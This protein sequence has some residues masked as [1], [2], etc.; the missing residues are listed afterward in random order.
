MN[1]QARIEDRDAERKR[2]ECSP[3]RPG[4][5][6]DLPKASAQFERALQMRHDRLQQTAFLRAEWPGVMGVEKAE[7]HR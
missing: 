4:R 1:A 5:L 2:V 7:R 3:G 6:R